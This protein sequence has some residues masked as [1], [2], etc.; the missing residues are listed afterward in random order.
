MATKIT[1][2]PPR[3]LAEQ[4]LRQ[5]RDLLETE[6]RQRTTELAE[7]NDLLRQERDRLRSNAAA[8]KESE[9]RFR[10]VLQDAPVTV[11]NHDRDLRYTW[12][13]NRHPDISDDTILGQMD[14]DLFA[15]AEAAWLTEIK[16]Q[17]LQ[18]GRGIREGL[19]ITIN[20]KPY[21]YDFT[22]EPL[23][24]DNDAIVGLTGVMVDITERKQTERELEEYA[25]KQRQMVRL[26]GRCGV[27]RAGGPGA[28]GAAAL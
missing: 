18:T 13:Y 22:M 11:F 26:P 4:E 28:A 7:A 15:P 12:V 20:G 14:A 27:L 8:L 1:A 16:R 3:R 6:V 5:S 25:Q 9:G 10:M 2:A 19:G 17:V 21:F 23:L 24:D